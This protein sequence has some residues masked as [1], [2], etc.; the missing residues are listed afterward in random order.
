MHI[1][2]FTVGHLGA[3]AIVGGGV[4]IATG[5]ALASR[6]F[7]D[8]GVVCC[9]AGDG[10]YAN[11]VVL[12][13]AE[14]RRPVPVHQPL[15][16]WARLRSADRLS[17]LQQPLRHDRSR[18]RRSVG[19]EPA[20]AARG[21]VRRQPHARRGRQR[22]ERPG[23][24]RRGAAGSEALPRRQGAGADR[25]RLLSLL[26][27]LA[28]RPAQRISHQGRGSGLEGHRRDRVLQEGTDRRR[29]A[30]RLRNRAGGAARRRAQCARRQTRRRRRRPRRQGRPHFH[31]H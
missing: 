20:G 17:G 29:G 26:G 11:G 21:G 6:Y 31:V 9:F 7:G 3:N 27:P 16:R 10:A 12:E 22:H 14:F 30:R 5:A 23:R 25:S 15:R 28:Q 4:P 2:D 8:N 24:A 18:R 1:A 13:V 19:R